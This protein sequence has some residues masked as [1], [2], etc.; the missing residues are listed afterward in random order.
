MATKKFL[1]TIEVEC[2]PDQS[3]GGFGLTLGA[4]TKWNYSQLL[5]TDELAVTARVVKGF[6][7]CCEDYIEWA[8]TP[9]DERSETY[10]PFFHDEGCP[11]F[12]EITDED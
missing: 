7:A 1:V 10:E 4:P 12:V 11:H 8:S 9:E 5:S 6:E 2:D 3:L